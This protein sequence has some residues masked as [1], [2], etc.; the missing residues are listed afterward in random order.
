MRRKMLEGLRRGYIAGSM[1]LL[2][3]DPIQDMY[4]KRLHE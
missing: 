1:L 3:V 4:E 2:F